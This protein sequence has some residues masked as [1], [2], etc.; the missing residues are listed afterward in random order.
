MLLLLRRSLF[1]ARLAEIT[2][3][4]GNIQFENIS[5][6]IAAGASASGK[7]PVKSRAPDG[8]RAGC[9]PR[10][11]LHLWQALLQRCAAWPPAEMFPQTIKPVTPF[12]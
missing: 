3:D 11:Q 10:A 1:P 7:K 9:T 12:A 5:V 2:D 8:D 6:L 4:S